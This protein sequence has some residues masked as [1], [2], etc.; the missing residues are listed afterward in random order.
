MPNRPADRS[1]YDARPRPSVAF[2][3]APP[4]TAHPGSNVRDQGSVIPMR[5][6]PTSRRCL[7][8]PTVQWAAETAG[9]SRPVEG[10]GHT[11]VHSSGTTGQ[12]DCLCLYAAS[13]GFAQTP[14][15]YGSDELVP[16]LSPACSEHLTLTDRSPVPPFPI[17]RFHEVGAVA[18]PTRQISRKNRG[19]FR[20]DRYVESR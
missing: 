8:L 16:A 9:P 3:K 6:R 20:R 19:S 10:S 4:V 11:R 18:W 12:R 2:G 5:D 15:S 17:A 7:V 13:L 1:R 14:E